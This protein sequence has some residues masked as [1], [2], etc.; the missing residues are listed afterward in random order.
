MKTIKIFIICIII[1]QFVY[2]QDEST[3]LLSEV[4]V[5]PATLVGDKSVKQFISANFV[6]P[7]YTVIPYEG[8]QVVMFHVT[9][10]G[11]LTDFEIIHSVSDEIDQEILRVLSLTNGAW[12]PAQAN[13]VALS[14]DKEIA[15]QI[16]YANTATQAEYRDFDQIAQRHFS[17][18]A[19]KLL[20][21]KNPQAAERRFEEALRYKPYDQNTL[22][23]LALCNLQLGEEAKAK[24]YISR[25][26][27][28]SDQ[29]TNLS[30]LT[31]SLQSQKNYDKLIH[32]LASTEN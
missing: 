29:E 21:N 8:T 4:E 14:A 16:K 7:S 22:A 24:T 1:G 13:G 15:V 25:I 10:T 9:E 3:H 5:T 30:Q 31:E 12:N 6:Y 20:E 11:Q 23:M 26:K 2:A 28:I 27:Q 18:G 32:L 17:K 19:E